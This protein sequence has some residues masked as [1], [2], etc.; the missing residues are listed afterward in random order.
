MKLFLLVSPQC[1]PPSPTVGLLAQNSLETVLA[2][3]IKTIFVIDSVLSH[4]SSCQSWFMLLPYSCNSPLSGQISHFRRTDRDNL[5][6]KA[7]NLR[8][9]R[10]WSMVF[11]PMVSDVWQRKKVSY[12]ITDREKKEEGI[13]T[14]ITPNAWLSWPVPSVRCCGIFWLHSDPSKTGNKNY[15]ESEGRVS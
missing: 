3:I 1:T 12:L 7:F 9:Q 13:G 15:H 11:G 6:E 14:P 10:V 2:M 5:E 4:P 8:F